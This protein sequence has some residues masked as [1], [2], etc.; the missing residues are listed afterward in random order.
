MD[1]DFHVHRKTQ[2]L[3]DLFYHSYCFTAVVWNQTRYISEVCLYS[4]SQANNK[5]VKQEEP[6]F[7]HCGYVEV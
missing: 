5:T 7:C 4:P 1:C 2:N 3:C 6:S